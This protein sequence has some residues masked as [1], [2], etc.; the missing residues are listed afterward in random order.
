MRRVTILILCLTVLLL[1]PAAS[2]QADSATQL[3]FPNGNSVSIVVDPS[4][5][6]VFVSG[7]PGNSSVVVLNYA[8]TILK[9]IGGEGGAAGMALD[10]ATHTLY[11]A[12]HDSTAISEINTQTLTETK[13]FSTAPYAGPS[14]VVIAGGKLWFSCLEGETG[15]LVSANLD[16]TGLTGTTGISG[17]STLPALLRAGGSNN[18]LLALADRDVEPPDVAVYDVSGATPTLVSSVHDP[19]GETS[20][21]NDMT[22]D[23]SGAN[24]LLAA[25]A[26]YFVQSLGTSNLL[27]SGD[28]PTG[29][30]PN[31]VAV[32]A[33]GK[34]VAGGVY[35]ASADDV[36]VYPVGSTTAVRTWRLVPPSSS[37][38]LAAASLAFSPDSSRLFAVAQ[39]ATT[40]HLAFNVLTQPTVPL[41]P[42]T[43]SLTR[44][45]PSSGKVRYGSHASL[46]VQ[47]TGPGTAS[48]KVDLYATTSTTVK[49]L[50][51][52]A[53]LS[54][55]VATFSV[56][57]QL[58]T[59]YTAQLE[60]GSGY[61]S[62]TS[63]GVTILVAPVLSVTT[64][65]AGKTRLQGHRASKTLLTAKVK[66]VLP[67]EPLGFVVQ[68]HVGRG[69]RTV[70]T[71]QFPVGVGGV[72]HVYFVTNKAGQC[73]VRVTYGGDTNYVASKSPWKKFRV[74]SPR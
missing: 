53:T 70:G 74:R 31:A 49:T 40:G 72:V 33:N 6:H 39:D 26:P 38:D 11:V 1:G 35:S 48:G 68:R 32:T 64:H 34:F 66:P 30:Y 24:L 62:S 18:H 5:G 51:A 14:S 54:S 16:G 69:W 47:A 15:C 56:A 36:F 71:G 58:K 59:T 13:R 23:P 50:V 25:G 65:P 19:N 22:F 2:A 61:A 9:T 20:F 45:T 60:Q 46:K 63:P 10:S 12:L 3:P 44:V 73:R 27:P 52:S 17:F 55:G 37:S 29:P 7:G 57:P 67:P 4:A 41:A 8:G 28:Y 43:T 21:V 42:T